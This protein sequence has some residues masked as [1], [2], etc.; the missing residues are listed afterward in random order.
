MCRRSQVISAADIVTK[1]PDEV[2][3][4][5]AG[6]SAIVTVLRLLTRLLETK[7]TH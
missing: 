5:P 3:V 7:T 6:V 4:S 1:I 2:S